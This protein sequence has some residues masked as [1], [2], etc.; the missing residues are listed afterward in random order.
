LNNSLSSIEKLK[1]KRDFENLRL[2][3]KSI[4]TKFYRIKYK[5]NSRDNPR[6]GIIISKK[7]HKLAVQRN[8]FKRRIREIFRTHKS[9]INQ[10][11][12][13]LIIAKNDAT[14]ASYQ[15]LLNDFSRSLHI[16]E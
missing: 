14:N 1:K 13:I 11:I 12:D 3:T 6:I 10:N 8:L 15:T 5:K 7:V 9:K 2:N 4:N 16:I